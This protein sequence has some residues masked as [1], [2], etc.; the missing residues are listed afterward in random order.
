M[1]RTAAGGAVRA[2]QRPFALTL[3]TLILA[4]MAVGGVLIAYSGVVQRWL[5]PA[6]AEVVAPRSKAQVQAVA[7]G[8]APAA[9]T[10]SM[11]AGGEGANASASELPLRRDIVPEDSAYPRT[12][13]I[14]TVIMIAILAVGGVAL[15]EWRAMR[16]KAGQREPPGVEEQDAS[17]EPQSAIIG[18]HELSEVGD[19]QADLLEPHDMSG[20]SHN[21]QRPLFEAHRPETASPVLAAVNDLSKKVEAADKH[22][23]EKFEELNA[24]IESMKALIKE[25]NGTISELLNLINKGRPSPA[26]GSSETQPRIGG[27][28]NYAPLANTLTERGLKVNA[29]AFV[30]RAQT[31]EEEFVSHQTLGRRAPNVRRAAAVVL[32]AADTPNGLQPAHRSLLSSLFGQLAGSEVGL[33]W[34]EAGTPFLS[35]EHMAIRRESEYGNQVADIVAPGM[36]DNAT[37]EILLRALVVVR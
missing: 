7:D 6:S 28:S 11:K 13:V 27:S 15:F 5:Q 8:A 29:S 16:R 21:P 32:A 12:L 10:G 2:P 30:L 20:A 22:T 37:G 23:L 31:L 26:A 3:I 25:Q 14:V 24:A 9:D 35:A 4:I 17:A 34:P 18:N 1:A 19:T 36:K 33:I